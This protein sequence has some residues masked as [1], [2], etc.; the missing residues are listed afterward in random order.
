MAWR[1][2]NVPGKFRMEKSEKVSVW[3]CSELGCIKV[4][5][6]LPVI[7]C[8]DF[9]MYDGVRGIERVEAK[10]MNDRRVSRMEF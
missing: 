4:G 3:R 7:V 6:W 5:K 9:S 2:I 8:R 1:N 10:I